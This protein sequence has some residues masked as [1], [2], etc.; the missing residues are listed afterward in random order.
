MNDREYSNYQVKNKVVCRDRGWMIDEI[1][2]EGYPSEIR[3]ET[4]HI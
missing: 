1:G 2:L 3:S 4:Y